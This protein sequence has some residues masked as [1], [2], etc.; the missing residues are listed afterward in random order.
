MKIFFGPLKNLSAGFFHIIGVKWG[1]LPATGEKRKDVKLEFWA[2]KERAES[3]RAAG[4]LAGIKRCFMS[5]DGDQ[6][7]GSR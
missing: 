3:F 7:K 6:Q 1:R 4:I 5:G 2:S